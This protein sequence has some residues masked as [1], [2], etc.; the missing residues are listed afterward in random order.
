VVEQLPSESK[1]S[2]TIERELGVIE[3]S[4]PS[5]SP[6]FGPFARGGSETN[7]GAKERIEYTVVTQDQDSIRINKKYSLKTAP[8]QGVTHIDMSGNGELVFDRRLGVFRLE[9][10]SY[11]IRVNEANVSVHIPLSLD[12]RL[13]SDADAAVQKKREEEQLA[14]LKAEIAARAEADK[15]KPLVPGER[16]SLSKALRSADDQRVQ[17]AAKRLSKTTA[18]DD[19]TEFSKPLCAAYKNKNEWTQ[20]ELM[21]ALRVWAGPDAEN[22]VIEGSRSASFMVR[23]QAIPVLGKFKTVA[24]AEAAAA[25]AAHNGA[26]VETAMKA[27]GPIAEPAAISLL[28]SSDFWVRATAANVLAEIGGKKA[29]AALTRELRLHVHHAHDVETAVIAMEKRLAEAGDGGETS[30]KDQSSREEDVEKPEESGAATMGIWHA[31]GGAFAVQATFVELNSGKVTLKKANGRIIKVPLEK[32]SKA[33]QEYATRQAKA[34]EGK[35][36][37]PFQ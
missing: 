7:R 23:R 22:T 20:A 3:R 27:M 13:M 21:A 25:Q 35:S 30:G 26:E 10:M 8:E 31:A 14:K 16:E 6:H 37:N 28:D 19:P 9:K 5:W 29:L 18:G 24:A 4:E 1:P 12:Y 15:P 2:W 32:L 11:D 17:N 36:E 33:D 34:L